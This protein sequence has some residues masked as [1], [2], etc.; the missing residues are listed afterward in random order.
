MAALLLDDEA[1][2][3]EAALSLLDE[4]D[5]LTALYSSHSSTAALAANV[6]NAASAKDD[7]P[8]NGG[9]NLSNSRHH[10]ALSTISSRSSSSSTY[11]GS[12]S[13]RNGDSGGGSPDYLD[14]TAS[15]QASGQASGDSSTGAVGGGAGGLTTEKQKQKATKSRKRPIGFNSNHARDERRKELIYLRQKVEELETQLGQLQR[16]NAEV[17]STNLRLLPPSQQ[18]ALQ[19]LSINT[20]SQHGLTRAAPEGASSLSKESSVWKELATRQHAEREKAEMEN[21]RLKLIL[22]EQIKIAKNL[23][24]MLTKKT[25]AKVRILCYVYIIVMSSNIVMLLLGY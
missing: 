1:E 15:G 2:G 23:H 18:N 19:Q 24:T 21:I 8:F 25:T 3:L 10:R 12:D 9:N 5:E 17:S 7:T 22:E 6:S 4:Y 13:G 11:S 16:P 14:S 20:W